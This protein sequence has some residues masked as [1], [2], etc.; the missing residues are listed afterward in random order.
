MTIDTTLRMDDP[1]LSIFQLGAVLFVR[2]EQ[3]VCD[4]FDRP[5]GDSK[6][7]KLG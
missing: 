2:N 1:Q 4:A 3:P 6:Q 5:I 7:S